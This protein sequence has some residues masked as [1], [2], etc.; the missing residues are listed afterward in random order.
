[1]ESGA[2]SSPPFATSPAAHPTQM[3]TRTRTSFACA[4]LAVG[5]ASGFDVST[6]PAVGPPCDP[7]QLPMFSTPYLLRL[8]PTRA[9]PIR[10]I[11]SQPPRSILTAIN[12]SSK[13][14]G[15]SSWSPQGGR[16]GRPYPRFSSGSLLSLFYTNGL[17]CGRC[18]GFRRDQ[19][20]LDLEL[21]HQFVGAQ[22]LSFFF[23]LDL[24]RVNIV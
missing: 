4:V 22:L 20:H 24:L 14:S 10:K 11:R 23:D 16:Q 8:Y 2:V 5:R 17:L 19:S 3:L 6:F 18:G 15:R 7:N 13:V 1:M 12:A 9:S 21:L